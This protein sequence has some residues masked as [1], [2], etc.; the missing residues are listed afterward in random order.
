VVSSP[1]I[2][3]IARAWI[4]YW[5]EE[6]RTG[7]F[8]ASDVGSFVFNL[9]ADMAWA[10]IL[11]ILDKVNSDPKDV[12]FQVLAASPTEDLL[13]EHGSAVIDRVEA[14]ALRNPR[15]KLLLGGVWRGRMSQEIW[16]R[17]EQCRGRA[18]DAA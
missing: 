10:V 18:W 15:F 16:A 1:D 9:D 13:G 2:A 5:E 17:V 3:Q 14:E 11:Q 12:L 8:P 6:E 4:A 7:R